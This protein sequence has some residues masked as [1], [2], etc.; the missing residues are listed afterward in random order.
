L[1]RYLPDYG[2]DSTGENFMT[3]RN[4]DATALQKT[5]NRPV[6]YVGVGLHSGRTAAIFVRPAPPDAGITFVRKDVAADKAVVEAL[7]HNVTDSKLS[8][9]LRNSHG[10]TVTTVEHLIAALRGCGVD[11]AR[12]ELTGEE[13]PIMDGSSEPFVRMIEQ[14]GTRVQDADRKLLW[15]HR[16]VEYRD[17][18]SYVLIMPDD[19]CRFTVQIDF[20]ASAI[21][22]QV[23]SVELVNEAFRQHIA[24]A[25]TFGFADKLEALRKE[26][27][28]KGG[29]LQNAVLVDG[30]RIVNEDG[31]RFTNEF[32]RHKLLDCYG[33]FGLIGHQLV[34]HVFARRPGHAVN[35][36]VVRE[37]LRQPD[38]WSL[39]TVREY[40]QLI[41]RRVEPGDVRTIAGRGAGNGAGKAPVRNASPIGR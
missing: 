12:V 5:L 17:G 33:D 27:L 36:G 14:A 28:I 35:H 38:M 30:D 25:R 2:L 24:P 40:Y 16:P 23:Y 41:G 10:T 32:V 39:V 3:G 34:G 11:N 9:V 26:G 6:S 7:W 18:D 31:L 15:L 22:T 29:S 20:P 37:L 4:H 19:T 21:G 8:T 13:V 1:R